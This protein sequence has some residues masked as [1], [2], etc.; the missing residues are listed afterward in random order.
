[1]MRTLGIYSLNNF[2]IHHSYSSVSSSYH[3]GHDISSACLSDHW[4][5]VPSDPHP[6]SLY[7]LLLLVTTNLISLSL[8]L[9]L[10]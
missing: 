7:L 1:M 10:V 8:S 2:P 9:S 4:E 3:V 5:F 6:I